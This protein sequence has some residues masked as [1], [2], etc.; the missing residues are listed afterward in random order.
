MFLDQQKP[1]QVMTHQTKQI[2]ATLASVCPQDLYLY[3]GICIYISE[4]KL[5]I[6][7]WWVDFNLHICT[8]AHSALPLR[9]RVLFHLMAFAQISNKCKYPLEDLHSCCLSLRQITLMISRNVQCSP[10]IQRLLPNHFQ[11]V[12]SNKKYFCKLPLS[13][14]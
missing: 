9:S 12:L 8:A 4:M 2:P 6:L 5:L 1:A 7:S 13:N 11:N 3:I 14:M 10:K